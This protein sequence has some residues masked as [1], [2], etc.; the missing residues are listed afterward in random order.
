MFARADFCRQIMSLEKVSIC[1]CS[2]GE[3]ICA[4]REFVCTRKAFFRAHH[5]FRRGPKE[6]FGA[7]RDFVRSPTQFR[8]SGN[9]SGTRPTL[10]IRTLRRFFLAA[11]HTSPHP[12]THRE[13]SRF[14]LAPGARR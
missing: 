9:L 10:F 8:S 4:H 13:D 11:R 2:H 12:A 14:S 6:F 7:P 3:F 1:T 5:E